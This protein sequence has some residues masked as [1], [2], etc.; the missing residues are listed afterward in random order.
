M[1]ACGLQS[2]AVACV[3]YLTALCVNVSMTPYDD[4]LGR[5]ING[6]SDTSREFA[7][8]EVT[9]TTIYDRTLT[10]TAAVLI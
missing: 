8:D 5:L 4:R 2:G 10:R 1:R 7:S 3:L 6:T 9:M